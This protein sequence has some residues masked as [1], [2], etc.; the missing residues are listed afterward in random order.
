MRTVI[1]SNQNYFLYR[2]WIQK[3]QYLATKFIHWVNQCF[4]EIS[5]VVPGIIAR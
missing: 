2:T 3:I 4:P 1:N 5:W